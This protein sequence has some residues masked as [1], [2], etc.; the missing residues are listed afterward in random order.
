[1]SPITYQTPG[2]NSKSD[3]DFTGQ[4]VVLRARSGRFA[5]PLLQLYKATGG[6]GCR[7][8]AL[9]S[10]VFVRPIF[11]ET[12]EGSGQLRFNNA[13]PMEEDGSYKARRGDVIGTVDG[14]FLD[15]VAASNEHTIPASDINDLCVLVLDPASFSWGKDKTVAACLKRMGKRGVRGCYIAVIHSEACVT[16][17]GGISTPGYALVKGRDHVQWVAN[18]D[19]AL[20]PTL[21]QAEKMAADFIAA[22]K[23]QA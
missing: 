17:M 10:G 19:K 16:D 1:M 21:A 20:R 4:Y 12:P 23:V 8:D 14:R 2:V 3:V 18:P 11:V 13:G 7:P 15:A 5:H 6:S 22:S 9:G